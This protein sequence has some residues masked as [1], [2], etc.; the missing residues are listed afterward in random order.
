MEKDNT[1]LIIEESDDEKT[2]EENPAVKLKLAL[3]NKKLRDDFFKEN[4]I[5]KTTEI[6]NDDFENEI[7]ESILKMEQTVGTAYDSDSDA[8]AT[9]NGNNKKRRTGSSS[10]TSSEDLEEDES[11][12]SAKNTKLIE[13][14]VLQRNMYDDYVHSNSVTFP[15]YERRRLS[16]C[17]EESE[18]DEE[19]EVKPPVTVEAE[20]EAPPKK[21]FT[22]TKANDETP[23]KQP[24]SILKKTPSPP[25]NQKLLATHSPKKIRYEA[26]ALKD[27]SAHKNSQTI[28]F[29]C[30]SAAVERANVKSFFSPQ[31]FLKPHLDRRY[32]D[33]SLVEVRASQTLN[34][35]SKSLDNEKGNRVVDDN[36]WIK[37]NQKKSTDDKISISSDSLDRS[38]RIGESVS[39]ESE[40]GI[41]NF[42]T[43]IFLKRCNLSNSANFISIKSLYSET[44]QVKF[45]SLRM[46]L[47]EVHHLFGRKVHQEVNSTK[48]QRSK[49][50]RLS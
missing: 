21:R 5:N 24:V 8:A 49:I 25:S 28:H 50:K 36:V 42:K 17:K 26:G 47:M 39:W 27:V 6:I 19:V 11:T 45:I 3:A 29:P 38:N 16:E 34:N 1:L 31:G 20:I 12:I 46:E 37:R 2:K 10:S 33:T 32:Y 43:H 22:V 48:S 14:S 7:D 30:T 23:P 18:T 35:S 44:N 9:S 40:L 13:S 41:G 4:E 15:F